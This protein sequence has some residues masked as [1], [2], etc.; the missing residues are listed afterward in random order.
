MTLTRFFAITAFICLSSATA[1]AQSQIA[2]ASN[3]AEPIEITA[4][5]SL[6]WHRNDLKYIANG[7]AV[8]RQGAISIQG[9]TLTA[10]YKSTQASNIDIWQLTAV[11]NVIIK[12]EDSTAY[13]DKAVYNVETET[14]T[15]T[16]SDLK[17]VSPDQTIT[18]TEKFIYK[19]TERRA[20]AV[21][22]AKVVRTEDKLEANTIEA[23]FKEEG[24]GKGQDAVETIEARGN[25]VITTPTEVLTGDYAIYRSAS[26]KAE[27]RGDVKITRGPNVLEGARAEV[28]LTTNVSKMFGAKETGER[29]R[30]IFYPKSE[31]K[32]DQSSRTDL[33]SF[34]SR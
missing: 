23:V 27:V 31:K 16:G 25:V 19:T 5:Q 15:L 22:N 11:S 17:L 4:Q 10:D 14:A 24:S 28:D 21:G 18:A 9:E 33:E 2:N 7:A 26:N 13:G 29:V 30:G 6:E 34:E 3:S 12:N 32:G 8:A 20:T 1:Q